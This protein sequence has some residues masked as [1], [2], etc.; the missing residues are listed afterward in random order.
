MDPDHEGIPSVALLV[1]H[2]L[3]G[4]H[5]D[6][7]DRLVYHR[8]RFFKRL[9][10]KDDPKKIIGRE[11]YDHGYL[12]QQMKVA[13]GLGLIPRDDDSIKFHQVPWEQAIGKQAIVRVDADKEKFTKN[14]EEKE[15]TRYQV[16]FGNFFR[17][18]DDAVAEVPKNAE[19]LAVLTGGAG[20]NQDDLEDI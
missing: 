16:N 12:S 13:A 7:R 3:E 9:R 5:P 20:I 6:Q 14:G 18:D 15:I 19:A 4:E 8:V 1:L 10:D 17:V 11:P 2:I